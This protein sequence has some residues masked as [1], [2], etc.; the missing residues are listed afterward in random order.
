MSTPTTIIHGD[1]K[2]ETNGDLG[3]TLYH[4]IVHGEK[5]K[6]PGAVAYRAASYHTTL[7]QALESAVRR[8]ADDTD[9][10]TFEEYIRQLRR[11]VDELKAG[12]AK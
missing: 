9:V 1:W 3:W 8:T 12:V 7:E 2:F 10:A 6:T 4:K 5:S 11:I